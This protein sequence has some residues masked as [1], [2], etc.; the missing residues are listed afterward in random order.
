VARQTTC[1]PRDT[2]RRWRTSAANSAAGNS[3]RNG[4]GTYKTPAAA[5]AAALRQERPGSSSYQATAAGHSNSTAAPHL[6]APVTATAMQ[7]SPE[8]NELQQASA[9]YLLTVAAGR[10]RKN[11]VVIL[12]WRDAARWTLHTLSTLCVPL[13]PPRPAPEG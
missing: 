13:P 12:W 4:S 2:E 11:P 10:M 8:A 9:E 7:L 1:R 3:S 6:P 5:A